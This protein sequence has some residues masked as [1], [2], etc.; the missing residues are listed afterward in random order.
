[1]PMNP[2]QFQKGLSLPAFLVRY[3]TEVQ[4]EQAL[5]RMRWPSGFRCPRC[6]HSGY[7]RV[8]QGNQ[9]LYQCRA[10]RHQ[11]S[12]RVGMIYQSSKLPLTVWFLAVYLKLRLICVSNHL[13]LRQK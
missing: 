12:A 9:R 3:G 1:M 2:I 13:F 6:G 4:C 5:E 10:C 8:Q 7:T 11:A